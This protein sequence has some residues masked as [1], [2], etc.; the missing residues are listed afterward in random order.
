MIFD[1]TKLRL[2]SLDRLKYSCALNPSLQRNATVQPAVFKSSPPELTQN[3]LSAR[4]HAVAS[5]VL[6][7]DTLQVVVHTTNVFTDDGTPHLGTSLGDG[8]GS[9][10]PVLFDQDLHLCRFASLVSLADSQ[11]LQLPI[12]PTD[13]L[14]LEIP[15]EAEG[16]LP[17]QVTPA[18]IHWP[19]YQEPGQAPVIAWLPSSLI[20]PH[21]TTVP[22][23]LLANA[24][25]PEVDIPYTPLRVWIDAIKHLVAHNNG[26]SLTNPASTLLPPALIEAPTDPPLDPKLVESPSVNCKP[27]MHTPDFH[28]PIFDNIKN[29]VKHIDTAIFARATDELNI[30][31]DQPVTANNGPTTPSS[32]TKE[33]IRGL[34]EAIHSQQA[35]QSYKEKQA[36]SASVS[37]ISRYEI[38]GARD[39]VFL[40]DTGNQLHIPVAGTLTPAFKNFL[41][42]PCDQR[43]LQELFMTQTMSDRAADTKLASYVRFQREMVCPLFAR[44]L[45][46]G[47]WVDTSVHEKPSGVLTRISIFALLQPI[48]TS[49]TYQERQKDQEQLAQQIFVEEDK[50][51][52]K[53]RATQL[54]VQGSYAS[55][56]SVLQACALFLSLWRMMY[57]NADDTYVWC[58]IKQHLDVIMSERGQNF[59]Q[60]FSKQHAIFLNFICDLQN[61][62]TE[63]VRISNDPSLRTKVSN[64]DKELPP[65]IFSS[66]LTWSKARSNRLGYLIAD[67]VPETYATFP[68]VHQF[69]RPNENKSKDAET[70]KADNKSTKT[71]PTNGKEKASAD[72]K[73]PPKKQKTDHPVDPALTAGPLIYTAKGK[74]PLPVD[75]KFKTPSGG[76]AP[77]CQNGAVQGRQCIHGTNCNWFH[78]TKA[79]EIHKD[80]QT[81]FYE[82]VKNTPNLEWAPG[83]APGTGTPP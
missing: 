48:T 66:A 22:T 51:R 7:D 82:W 13:P 56:S 19:E 37:T 70:K 49:V 76:L 74:L 10:Y 1:S 81:A 32:D 78:F 38:M 29:S 18:T 12:S 26:L 44:L 59:C 33:L 69:T 80:N 17:T 57:E 68:P 31:L 2:S 23:G 20:I 40:D 14:Q 15:N 47:H 6:L 45:H 71:K 27:K 64:G 60:T 46:H 4:D 30:Q 75:M 3:L 53:T 24:T 54:Y 9:P 79:S 36:K 61:M 73:S 8:I 62:I 77:L 35:P 5:L 63:L 21:G 11:A 34:T 55:Y 65:A 52:Q 42:K 72:P 43:D 83:C 67:F 16:E 50:S 58:N 25:V 39:K 28:H 41:E